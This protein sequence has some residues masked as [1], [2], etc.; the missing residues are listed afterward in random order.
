MQV[1]KIVLYL[2]GKVNITLYGS[3]LSKKA[4]LTKL[5]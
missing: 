5:G 1:S 3:S 4:T 2:Q